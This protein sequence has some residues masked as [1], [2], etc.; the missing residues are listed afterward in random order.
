MLRIISVCAA[1]YIGPVDCEALAAKR[2][3][4]VPSVDVTAR[5]GSPARASSAQGRRW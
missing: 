3:S 1:A 2:S 5:D 4:L